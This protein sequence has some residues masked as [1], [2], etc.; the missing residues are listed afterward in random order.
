ML[1]MWRRQHNLIP[2]R[3]AGSKPGNVA[4]SA[5]EWTGFPFAQAPL[6]HARGCK[7]RQTLETTRWRSQLQR[8]RFVWDYGATRWR[9]QLPLEWRVGSVYLIT[10]STRHR[11]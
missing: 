2:R 7:I 6:A 9:S 5:S 8:T 11:R 3:S 4:A 10:F 1:E